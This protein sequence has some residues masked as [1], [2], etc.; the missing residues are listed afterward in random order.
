MKCKPMCISCFLSGSQ[1]SKFFLIFE[2]PEIQLPENI[3]ICFSSSVD[4]SWD[5]F[6]LL[7]PPGDNLGNG[8]WLDVSLQLLKLTAFVVLFALTLTSA[9]V[10][11]SSFLLMTSAIGWGGR[12]T[13]ICR[14]PTIPGTYFIVSEAFLNNS[15]EKEKSA[16]NTSVSHHKVFSKISGKKR[17]KRA[18]LLEWPPPPSYELRFDKSFLIRTNFCNFLGANVTSVPLIWS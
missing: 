15:C 14:I 9:V 7:P 2:K 13:T 4:R 18:D 11:K 17:R 6:R 8:L 16:N 10:A 1:P 3:Q 5:V 12:N